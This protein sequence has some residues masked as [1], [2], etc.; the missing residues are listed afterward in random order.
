MD[1]L[2]KNAEQLAHDAEAAAEAARVVAEEAAL[3]ARVAKVEAEAER[4]ARN[5]I[6]DDAE[7]KKLGTTIMGV[8]SNQLVISSVL[9]II[10]ATAD[11]IITAAFL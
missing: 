9:L 3:V 10:G 1:G 6:A 4:L 7:V 2:P 8:Q 5:E 11:H